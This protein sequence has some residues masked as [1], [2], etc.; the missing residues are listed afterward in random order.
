V[1]TATATV[2]GVRSDKP[3]PTLATRIDNQDGIT[4]LDGDAVVWRDPVVAR[5]S[6]NAAGTAGTDHERHEP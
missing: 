6:P 5:L 2:T 1:L 3:V 4:V